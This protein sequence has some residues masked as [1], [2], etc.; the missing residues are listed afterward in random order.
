MP[1]LGDVP[2]LRDQDVGVSAGG[3]FVLDRVIEWTDDIDLGTESATVKP[4]TKVIVVR[5]VPADDYESALHTSAKLAQQ[6]LDL[7]SIR[8]RGDLVVQRPGSTPT[9]GRCTSV[10]AA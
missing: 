10:R 8:G 1:S 5:G 3:A 6:G 7:L 9:R 2:L 4:G